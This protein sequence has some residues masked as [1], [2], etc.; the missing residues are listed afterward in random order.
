MT[1][2]AVVK[3]GEIINRVDVDANSKWSP[4]DGCF[5][6]DERDTALEI[7]G[8]YR[9]GVYSPPKRETVPLEPAPVTFLPQ[10]LMAQ[11][12]VAD[13]AKIR[14]AVESNVQFWLL[15]SSLQAQKDPMDV[16]AERVQQGWTAL[17][18]VLGKERMSDI[19]AKMDVTV[20][21]LDSR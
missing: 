4:P 2:L 10:D 6:L 13:A 1:V 21:A 8:F 19:A 14:D 7:G 16:T 17:I 11:F 18:H 15:W 12:T 5:T 9:D 20:I 3:D